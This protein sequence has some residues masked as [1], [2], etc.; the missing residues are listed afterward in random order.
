[1]AVTCNVVQTY[2]SV[3]ESY[4]V[5]FQI[6]S[7]KVTYVLFLDFLTWSPLGVKGLSEYLNDF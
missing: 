5:S 2:A 1:M 7:L 3:A 4:R 6:K